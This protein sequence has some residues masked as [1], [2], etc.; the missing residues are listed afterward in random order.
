MPTTDVTITITTPAAVPIATVVD[1]LATYW[2]YRDVINGQPNPQTKGQ[3]IKAKIAAF[4]RQQYIDAKAAQGADTG[5]QTA[6]TDASQVT[7]D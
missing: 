3:F 5:R 6:I 4:V 1:T 7:T 2:G